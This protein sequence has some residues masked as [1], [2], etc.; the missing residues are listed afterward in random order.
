M[1]RTATHQNTAPPPLKYTVEGYRGIYPA[2][3]LVWRKEVTAENRGQAAL[4]GHLAYPDQPA[5]YILVDLTPI[6]SRKPVKEVAR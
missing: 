4:A 5:D 2:G 6:G 1:R 3:Q